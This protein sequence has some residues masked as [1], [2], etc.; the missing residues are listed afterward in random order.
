MSDF[1]TMIASMKADALDPADDTELKRHVVAAL[2]HYRGERFEFSEKVGTFS[3]VADQEEYVQGVDD[4]PD[5]IFSIDELRITISS[6]IIKIP[7]IPWT[8]FRAKQKLTS[9]ISQPR[10]AAFYASSIWLYPTPGAIY[11]IGIDFVFDATVDQNGDPI[12]TASDNA[13]TNDFFTIG[14]ELVRTRALYTWAMTRGVS[15]E[16][17]TR[18]KLLNNEA[19]AR[20]RARASAVR[21]D[22]LQAP[23]YF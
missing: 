17:A 15:D 9:T 23:V 21:V 5:G 10:Y 18:M 8:E 12:T 4:V 7:M 22:G 14:E 2:N 16:F 13:D 3:T 6:R 20:L 11:T 19:Y 1:G